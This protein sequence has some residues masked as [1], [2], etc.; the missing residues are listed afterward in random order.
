MNPQRSDIRK[1][2]RVVGKNLASYSSK[3]ENFI[4]FGDFNAKPFEDAIEECM[5]VHYLKNLVKGLTC[6]KTP[7]R[8]SCKDLILTN[9]NKYFRHPRLSN[10][11]Q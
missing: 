9:E 11:K 10:K 8:S 5:K 7:G 2:L 1:Y 4:L 3:Y 6:C